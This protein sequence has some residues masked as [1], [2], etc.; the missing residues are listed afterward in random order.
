[1]TP[2]DTFAALE[3]YID[4][5]DKFDEKVSKQGVGWHL[6][7]VFRATIGTCQVLKKS[8]PNDY[9]W[10]FSFIRFAILTSNYIPRGK[11]RAPKIT[12]SQ[13][14]ITK[15]ALINQYQQVMQHLSE[16]EGL[17]AHSNFQHPYF[18]LLNLKTT[19]KF[20]RTHTH[21]HLKIVRDIVS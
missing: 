15:E 7:H 13:E 3:K 21:H 1:M 18:G 6:D 5:Q 16:I 11:G 12:T 10:K 4:H 8:N 2:Q 19:K 14:P 17:H 20:L 9:R